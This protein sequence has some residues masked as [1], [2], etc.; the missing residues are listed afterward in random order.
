MIMQC[1]LL[2]M[3]VRVI[4]QIER[5]LFMKAAPQA[6]TSSA[7][8]VSNTLLQCTDMIHLMYPAS[9]SATDARLMGDGKVSFS[10]SVL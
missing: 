6:L 9:I 5:Q 2:Y 3:P 7:G 8:D 4:G 10:H 1:T